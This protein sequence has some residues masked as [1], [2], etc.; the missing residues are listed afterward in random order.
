MGLNG[1][2][3]KQDD[4]SMIDSVLYSLE[5]GINFI[6]TARAYGR[7][8]E[9]VGKAL[10][11]WKGERPFVATKV[12]FQMSS[13]PYLP[14]AGFHYAIPIEDIYPQGAILRSVEQSLQALQLDSIDLIQMHTY[15]PQWDTVDY[16]MEELLRLK[17][18]G[19]IVSIG[20][21]LPDHRHDLGISLVR[22]GVIDSVQ[23]IVNVF[24]SLA[25]DALVDI[26]QEHEVAVLARVILDEG[27]LTGF[28]SK[29]TVFEPTDYR[30]G[31][32]DTLPRDVYLHQID[33]LRAFI[34]EHADNLAELAIKFVLHH[35][36][37]TTALTSMQIQ[38]YAAQ[39][40][41]VLSKMPLAKSQ[42]EFMKV[43][44]RWVKHATHARRNK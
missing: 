3:G 4:R 38:E 33:R 43:R 41:D 2:F 29:D 35:P 19:K 7:S 28:L 5:R 21:S 32:F 30:S 24:D 1:S 31:Y 42:F 25:F 44:H 27:G 17:E 11:E 13:T 20:I 37:I 22:S 23:T 40:I 16:W 18:S 9:L 26:C 34:P 39:N 15:W 12:G 8:E 6:D 36:G 14:G 10:K